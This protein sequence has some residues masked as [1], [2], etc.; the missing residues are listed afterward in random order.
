[1]QFIGRVLFV[2][3]EEGLEHTGFYSFFSITVFL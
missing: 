3:G 1:M 2:L